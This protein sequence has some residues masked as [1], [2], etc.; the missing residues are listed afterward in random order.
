MGG[1]N[2]N[3][4]N[5]YTSSNSLSNQV[6]NIKK[7]GKSYSAISGSMS[8]TS[9]SSDPSAGLNTSAQVWSEL[10]RI[11]YKKPDYEGWIQE[12]TKSRHNIVHQFFFHQWSSRWVVVHNGSLYIYKFD[13]EDFARKYIYLPN[14]II[15]VAPESYAKLKYFKKYV[16]KITDTDNTVLLLSFKDLT[17][18]RTWL[19]KF[20]LGKFHELSQNS[21]DIPTI[22]NKNLNLKK[23]TQSLR[24]DR[25]KKRTKR[26]DSI[27]IINKNKIEKL[28][29]LD[30]F[31]K[32]E[33][34]NKIDKTVKNNVPFDQN[35]QQRQKLVK[36]HPNLPQNQILGQ[37]KHQQVAV[38]ANVNFN[39]N[40]DSIVRDPYRQRVKYFFENSVDMIESKNG[41]IVQKVQFRSNRNK[42]RK[43]DSI[44][45]YRKSANILIK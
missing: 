43:Q 42:V 40:A 25:H 29:K 4:N 18:R 32:N 33:E 31:D 41:N 13:D 6:R 35:N 8:S 12:Y 7:Y 30:K 15:N 9:T 36:I 23:Q 21:Q 10:D 34:K 45:Q 28:N 3:K 17:E 26:Q 44:R 16:I 37:T 20:N 2:P 19:E 5:F 1:F 38:D 11:D 14:C 22:N 39:V 24:D 27:K